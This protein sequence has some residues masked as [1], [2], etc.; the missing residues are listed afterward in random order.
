MQEAES[1]KAH[2]QRRLGPTLF[3]KLAERDIDALHQAGYDGDTLRFAS[4]ESLLQL[5][6]SLP[7]VDM[8]LAKCGTSCAWHGSRGGEWWG[9]VCCQNA[10]LSPPPPS[11]QKAVATLVLQR[12]LLPPLGWF[13]PASRLNYPAPPAPCTAHTL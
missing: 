3:A 5:K 13:A 1:L 2:L 11:P 9:G 8:L 6:L 10:L 12:P 7:V 4:R